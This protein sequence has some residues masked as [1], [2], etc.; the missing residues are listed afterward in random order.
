MI[1]FDCICC[2]AAL[3]LTHIFGHS[4]AQAMCSACAEQV[5]AIGALPALPHSD[6]AYGHQRD[7]LLAL[8]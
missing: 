8:Y 2:G 1:E 7:D 5:E 3:D 6:A 4:P